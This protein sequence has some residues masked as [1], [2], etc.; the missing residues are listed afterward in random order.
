[1]HF[2]KRLLQL[3]KHFGYTQKRMGA[4]LHITHSAYGKKEKKAGLPKPHELAVYAKTFGLSEEHLVSSIELIM[5]LDDNYKP[6][7]RINDAQ[8][9]LN[10][11]KEVLMVVFKQDAIT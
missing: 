3:R 5:Y 7:V 11:L 6:A 2:G 4:L 9:K 8:L 1:M 10:M